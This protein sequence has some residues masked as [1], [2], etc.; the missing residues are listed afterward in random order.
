MIPPS[1]DLN[2]LHQYTN[3]SNILIIRAII[4]K[5]YFGVI[6]Q[7][8]SLKLLRGGLLYKQ[9]IFYPIDH[10]YGCK[11]SHFFTLG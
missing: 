5:D 6:A 4:C 3:N 11:V 9:I 1:L 7:F 8:L 10:L 2:N